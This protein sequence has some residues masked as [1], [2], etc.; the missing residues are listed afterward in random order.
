MSIRCVLW[1]DGLISLSASSIPMGAKHAWRRRLMETVNS[2]APSPLPVC[3]Q[4]S[5]WFTTIC[6]S[7]SSGHGLGGGRQRSRNTGWRHAKH[8]YVNVV[9]QANKVVAPTQDRC[10]CHTLWE[11]MQGSI[12]SCQQD[13]HTRKTLWR[14]PLREAPQLCGHVASPPSTR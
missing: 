8:F 9:A 4:V 1:T 6:Q 2:P 13:S 14:S 5:G 11:M 3:P 10:R 12:R 7:H